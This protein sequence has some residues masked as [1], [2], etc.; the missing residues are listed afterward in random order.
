MYKLQF[1]SIPF[2]RTFLN[3]SNSGGTNPVPLLNCSVNV[4]ARLAI[5]TH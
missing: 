5:C 4:C 2:D 1:L 3:M